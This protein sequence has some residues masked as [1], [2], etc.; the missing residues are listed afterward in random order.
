MQTNMLSMIPELPIKS[1]A[2]FPN[3]LNHSAS[4]GFYL[5]RNNVLEING[6]Y[7]TT[8][9]RNHLCDY[10]SEYKLDMILNGYQVGAGYVH[11]FNLDK[12]LI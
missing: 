7:L 10:S 9:G 1:I 4:I 12:K 2:H 11:I 5:N 8:G 3:Y 6:T